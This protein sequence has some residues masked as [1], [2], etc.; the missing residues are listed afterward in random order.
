MFCCVY[1]TTHF[2]LSFLC[3]FPG[4]VLLLL[5]FNCHP[6]PLRTLSN[7]VPAFGGHCSADAITDSKLRSSSW[8]MLSF[9]VF[10][11]GLTIACMFGVC[12]CVVCVLSLLAMV[13]NIQQIICSSCKNA[14]TAL[15]YKCADCP[16]VLCPFHLTLWSLYL[17][18]KCLIKI[19]VLSLY[20]Y[21]MNL[22]ECVS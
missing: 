9:S 18:Y 7:A 4:D 17:L 1:P 13:S 15:R 14:I 16:N 12:V 21:A 20:I 11:F 6:Q 22:S 5:Y 8:S 19:L 3:S 2:S 10:S